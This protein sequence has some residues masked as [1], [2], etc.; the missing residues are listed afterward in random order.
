M[1]KGHKAN[2]CHRKGCA[3]ALGTESP[4]VSFPD[5][6]KLGWSRGGERAAGQEVPPAAQGDLSKDF[7][8]VRISCLR[9]ST[10]CPLTLRAPS[11]T[12]VF[13]P[14][15]YWTEMHPRTIGHRIAAPGT[16]RVV[17]PSALRSP[18]LT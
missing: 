13:L 5:S 12:S 14:P 11:W 6:N 16:Q 8:R 2:K 15:L 7:H 1:K 9:F 3:V 4:P 10:V 17:S 18:G